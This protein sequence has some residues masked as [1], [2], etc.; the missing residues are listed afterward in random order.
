MNQY[1]DPTLEQDYYYN[2]DNCGIHNN[3]SFTGIKTQPM[4]KRKFKQDKLPSLK[5]YSDTKKTNNDFELKI[6]WS[7]IEK[8]FEQCKKTEMVNSKSKNAAQFQ[9]P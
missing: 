7:G 8:Y 6:G 9:T 3:Q 1:F 4:T 5:V 2:S